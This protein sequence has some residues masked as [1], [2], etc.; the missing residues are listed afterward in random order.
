MAVQSVMSMLLQ[1]LPE[2]ADS[3]YHLGLLSDHDTRLRRSH[4]LSV[5]EKSLSAGRFD[6][7]VSG[8]QHERLIVG[9]LTSRPPRWP[10][11]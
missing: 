9:L 6:F 4:L 1:M 8:K 7:K 11:G 10:S 5:V 3:L 2:A